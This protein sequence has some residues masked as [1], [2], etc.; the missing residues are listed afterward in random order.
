MQEP[1]TLDKAI[2]WIDSTVVPQVTRHAISGAAMIRTCVFRFGL[3]Y[4]AV[5]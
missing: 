4:L 1:K 5:T 2:Q 3:T